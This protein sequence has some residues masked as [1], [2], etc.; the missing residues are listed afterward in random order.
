MSK[1]KDLLPSE[2]R[3]EYGPLIEEGKAIAKAFLQASMD[4]EDASAHTIARAVVM[5]RSS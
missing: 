5:R 3:A 2:L 1:F 4:A